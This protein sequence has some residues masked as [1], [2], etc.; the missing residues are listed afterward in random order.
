MEHNSTFAAKTKSKTGVI[1]KLHRIGQL[2]IS[3]NFLSEV[4]VQMV[5]LGNHDTRIM[6]WVIVYWSGNFKWKAIRVT[7]E[8][9]NG[10]KEWFSGG[11]HTLY[12]V[13]KQQ[14]T[15]NGYERYLWIFGLWCVQVEEEFPA[16]FRDPRGY[17]RGY[18][19]RDKCY[20]AINDLV[21]TGF[22]L[23]SNIRLD[24]RY[25]LPLG[26]WSFLFPAHKT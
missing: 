1:I 20:Q 2:E 7:G 5:K 12:S 19:R 9:K 14:F 17:T 15:I 4:N 3:G 26:N 16:K 10:R 13:T 24:V 21:A 8:T 25:T 6:K 18:F 22:W 23:V 11:G